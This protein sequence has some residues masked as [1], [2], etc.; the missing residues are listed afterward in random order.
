MTNNPYTG[1]A[2]ETS[3]KS[4]FDEGFAAPDDDHPAPSPLDRDQQTVFAEGVLAGQDAGH[5]IAQAEHD[6]SNWVE[7]ITELKG[8]SKEVVAHAAYDLAFVDKAKV[9]MSLATGALVAFATIAIWGPKRGPF[10]EEAAA[11][12][13]ARII[14]ELQAQGTTTTENVELFMAACDQPTHAPESVNNHPADQFQL[15][16]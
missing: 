10:F 14:G 3:W 16:V 13:V 2:F 9:G 15:G 11:Q 6:P 8:F 5:G 12:A 4:G 1:S 7:V